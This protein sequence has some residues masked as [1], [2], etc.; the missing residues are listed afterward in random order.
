MARLSTGVVLTK[1]SQVLKLAP[2]DEF[3]LKLLT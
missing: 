2:G 1:S 3:A